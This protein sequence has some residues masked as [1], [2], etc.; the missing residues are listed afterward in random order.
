[1][2][3]LGVQGIL[4]LVFACWWVELGLEGS[5]GWCL[6]IGGQSW[7]LMLVPTHWRAELGPGVSG[8]GELVV[9]ELVLS[10]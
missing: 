6:P 2:A 5:W 4:E 1:M 10:C 9:L 7:V 8:C 3:G